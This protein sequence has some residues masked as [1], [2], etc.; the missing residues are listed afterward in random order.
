MEVMPEGPF[1]KRVCLAL[2]ALFVLLQMIQFRSPCRFCVITRCK[3]TYMRTYL[4]LYLEAW[5]R[6]DGAP[7]SNTVVLL[8]PQYTLLS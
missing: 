5:Y 6:V 1:G 8:P 2:S 4:G 7:V 3:C